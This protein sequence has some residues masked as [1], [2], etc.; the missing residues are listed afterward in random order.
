MLWRDYGVRAVPDNIC[1]ASVASLN[2]AASG[3]DV[4]LV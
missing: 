2:L 4:R 3:S 1:M